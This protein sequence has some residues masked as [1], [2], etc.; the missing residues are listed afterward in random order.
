MKGKRGRWGARG[1]RRKIG[2]MYL[3]VSADDEQFDTIVP[4]IDFAG[5]GY[6][7]IN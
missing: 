2:R 1:G 5:L 3:E 7:G 6:R 4:A